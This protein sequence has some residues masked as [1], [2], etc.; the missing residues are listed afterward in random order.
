[1]DIR[2]IKT[3][4][5]IVKYGSFQRAAEELQYVQSTITLHI[6]KLEKDIGQ[7]L[8]TRG[9]KIQ[10][11]EAGRLFLEKSVT[12]L[13]E[14]DFLYHSMVGLT[15]GEIG[16]IRIGVME[17]TASYRMP[18]IMKAF[19]Q[20]YPLVQVSI[21]IGNTAALNQ[22]L[23][24]D[25][26]D[27]ALCTTPESAQNHIFEPLFVEQVGLLMHKTH[28]LANQDTIY[29]RDMKDSDILIT[30]SGCPYRKKLESS[31]LEKGG[32][33]YHSIEIGNMSALKF[34]VQAD[35]GLAV[36]PIITADP[37]PENTVL[38]AVYDLNYGLVTGILR[39]KEPLTLSTATE[40]FLEILKEK[41][42]MEHPPLVI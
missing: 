10:L 11:T 2:S 35:F 38:K 15:S 30:T 21:Q 24:D 1:M 8:L 39:K 4:Q 5:T 20:K 26:I 34:Y 17:P 33:P 3:F 14:Y 36:V 27:I 41:I 29:L 13:K 12:L 28:P 42:R 19:M 32:L 22:M 18:H 16:V 6:Q 31:L 23:E 9:K 7:K 25:V 40:N 37:I